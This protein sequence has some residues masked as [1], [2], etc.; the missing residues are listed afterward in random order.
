MEYVGYYGQRIGVLLLY[1]NHA[2]QTTQD[3]SANCPGSRGT[4]LVQRTQWS[5]STAAVLEVQHLVTGHKVWNNVTHTHSVAT[6]EG[7]KM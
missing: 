7:Q 5:W 4:L 6:K 2:Q 1:R 3:Y